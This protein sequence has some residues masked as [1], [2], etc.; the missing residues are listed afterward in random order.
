[1]SVD[2]V[3]LTIFEYVGFASAFSFFLL[4]L[5]QETT[6][7]SVWG[8]MGSSSRWLISCSFKCLCWEACQNK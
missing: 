3:G 2:L 1:V 4:C 6:L 8:F 7:K 5:L